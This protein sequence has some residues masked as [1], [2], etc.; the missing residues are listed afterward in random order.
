LSKEQI[1]EVV[2]DYLSQLVQKVSTYLRKNQNQK[3]V[4]KFIHFQWT[5]TI[6]QLF[7]NALHH[8]AYQPESQTI[9]SAEEKAK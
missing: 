7:L 1:K 9:E 3:F 8:Q 5:S 6:V 2:Q 4:Y